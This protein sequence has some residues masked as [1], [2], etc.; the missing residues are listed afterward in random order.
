MQDTFSGFTIFTYNKLLF[1]KVIAISGIVKA[2]AD[3][4]YQDL[5]YSGYH[6]KLNLIIVLLFILLKKIAKNTLLHRT[7]FDFA[8]GI[9]IMHCMHNLQI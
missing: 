9:E 3:N 8:L 5:D 1:D 4:T 7:H 6:D 2:E